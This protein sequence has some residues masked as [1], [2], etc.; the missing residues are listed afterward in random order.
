M[1][2]TL[3][4]EIEYLHESA[5]V[6]IRIS[7]EVATRGHARIEGYGLTNNAIVEMVARE[8]RE[9]LLHNRQHGES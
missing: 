3:K 9:W 1:N 4:I 8:L 7:D 5:L 2:R 6:L